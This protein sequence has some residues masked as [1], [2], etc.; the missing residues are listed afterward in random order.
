VQFALRSS[1]KGYSFGDAQRAKCT[2]RKQDDT[3]RHLEPSVRNTRGAV[4]RKTFSAFSCL[5]AL[6]R[7]ESEKK[8]SAVA[9]LTAE[10]TAQRGPI[11]SK[12]RSVAKQQRREH[13]VR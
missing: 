7:I 1:S 5:P 4:C 3:K 13:G 10:R 6:V 12:Q 11:H 2:N 9:V 8:I